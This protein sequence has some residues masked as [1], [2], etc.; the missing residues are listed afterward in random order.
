MYREVH[1][2]EGNLLVH[3]E[4]YHDAYD[5]NKPDAFARFRDDMA[6]KLHETYGKYASYVFESVTSATL[7]SRK[8]HQKVLNPDTREPRQWYASATEDL[9]EFL[10]CRLAGLPYNVGI[11]LHA[12]REKDEVNETFVRT[13][14]APGR[15]SSRNQL[16]AFYPEVY[17]AYAQ[18]TTVERLSKEP[19]LY[20]FLQTEFGRLD[21]EAWFAATQINPPS[22]CWNDFRSLWWKGGVEKPQVW[23]GLVYGDTGAGKSTFFSTL[24]KPIW[25]WFFDGLGKE[26]PYLRLGTDS[27]LKQ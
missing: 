2:S 13:L 23:H 22:P 6:Y 17:R 9:E 18:Y 5:T 14:S 21:G 16:A 11:S 8:L 20:R 19:K 4:Y 12:A 25:V 15:L 3:I 7:A 26:M 1:D 24:P 27:G 10:C